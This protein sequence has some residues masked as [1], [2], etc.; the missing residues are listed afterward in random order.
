MFYTNASSSIPPTQDLNVLPIVNN[1]VFISTRFCIFIKKYNNKKKRLAYYFA[2]FKQISVVNE[3]ILNVPWTS[4]FIDLL[5]AFVIFEEERYAEE[6][7]QGYGKEQN[8]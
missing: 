7:H 8:T 1:F 3:A 4:S 6:V 2:L 5:S